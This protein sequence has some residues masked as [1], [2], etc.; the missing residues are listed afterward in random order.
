MIKELFESLMKAGGG[1]KDFA[2]EGTKFAA[3]TWW[4]SLFNAV[5]YPI[6]G[7]MLTG[8]GRAWGGVT[9]EATEA[10]GNVAT[11]LG[12]SNRT[13]AVEGFQMLG[14][15]AKAVGLES[16]GGGG[17]A[18]GV[19][20]AN[21]FTADLR[22]GKVD[23]GGLLENGYNMLKKLGGGGTVV[24]GTAPGPGAGQQ[25]TVSTTPAG[26]MPKPAG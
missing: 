13:I 23:L 19:H 1:V 15:G 11:W 6:L 5:L 16:N 26:G 3:T 7:R 8:L 21:M 20:S 10:F 18:S 25:Q 12:H 4:N 17:L 2:V 22:D 14:E 24:P 9:G